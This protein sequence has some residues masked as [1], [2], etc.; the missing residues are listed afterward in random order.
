MWLVYVLIRLLTENE[1]VVYHSG[2]GTYL[3]FEDL[4]YSRIEE[5]GTTL[6]QTECDM[7]CLI[8][9]DAM[10]GAM[11]IG[12]MMNTETI[13][14]IVASSPNPSHYKNFQK[15]GSLHME[16]MPLWARDELKNG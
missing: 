7:F 13:F 9:P 14:P 6:P 11:E 1:T 2:L 16:D 3:F 12:I 8:D 10:N 15:W 5:K 4:V